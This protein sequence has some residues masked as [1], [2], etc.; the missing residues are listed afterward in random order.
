MQGDWRNSMERIKQTKKELEVLKQM[1]KEKQDI[2]FCL[3]YEHKSK[4]SKKLEKHLKSKKD[5]DGG[6]FDV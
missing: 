5:E 1:V 3:I 4:G 2:L 6:D